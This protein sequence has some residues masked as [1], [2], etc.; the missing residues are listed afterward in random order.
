MVIYNRVINMGI[1]KE[2]INKLKELCESLGD[3]D[4]QLKVNAKTLW[5]ILEKVQ[6]I[7]GRVLDISS[8]NAEISES[9]KDIAIDLESVSE[10]VSNRGCRPAAGGERE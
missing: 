5:V 6:E 7:K 10:L 8:E 2:N 3:R 4:K 9:L 1:C